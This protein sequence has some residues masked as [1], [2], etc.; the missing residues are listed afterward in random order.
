MSKEEA[1]SSNV[2]YTALVAAVL[3][4]HEALAQVVLTRTGMPLDTQG[5]TG[6]TALMFAALWGQTSIAQAL[7]EAGASV[8]VVNSDG[9]TALQLARNNGHRDITSLLLDFGAT[10]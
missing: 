10:A 4:G 1:I 7:L 9:L 5:A 8:E 6:N 2:A 3:G